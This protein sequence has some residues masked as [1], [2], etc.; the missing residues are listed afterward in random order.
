MTMRPATT[1]IGLALVLGLALA[2]GCDSAKPK[3]KP[4]A[5]ESRETIG[6]T[7]QNVLKLSDA[8]RQGGV[9]AATKI[10]AADPLTQSASAYRTSVGKLSVMAVDQAIQLRNASNIQDPKPLSYDEFM[11]EII[12]KGQGEG[13]HL[14]HAPL[15]PGIRLGRGQPEARRRRV[16]GAEEELSEEPGREARPPLIARHSRPS[17]PDYGLANLPGV[18]RCDLP[19]A[20]HDLSEAERP[21][22][23]GGRGGERRRRARP[24]GPSPAPRTRPCPSPR[25]CRRC[26]AGG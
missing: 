5:Q 10:E 26:A 25:A 3:A 8:L 20:G 13:I 1:P 2:A 15:L 24:A 23:A 12:K 14:A 7:T 16:P 19:D 11:A 21:A 4:G 9:L 18:I 6:K 17:S 22:H